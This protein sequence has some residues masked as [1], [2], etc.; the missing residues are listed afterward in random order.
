MKVGK[1]DS[2]ETEDGDE[3]DDEATTFDI[4]DSNL[5]SKPLHTKNWNFQR[6]L[7]GPNG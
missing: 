4:N 7:V 3:E 6:P 2:I 5:S 1:A